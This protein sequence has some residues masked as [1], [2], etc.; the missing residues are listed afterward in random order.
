MKVQLENGVWLTGG[1][2]DPPRTLVEENAK[3]FETMEDALDALKEARKLRSFENALII[4][5]FV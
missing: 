1:Q 3:E 2:G 4:D 5:D